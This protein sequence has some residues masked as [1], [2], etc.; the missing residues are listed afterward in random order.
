MGPGSRLPKARGKI[1]NM[2]GNRGKGAANAPLK[3]DSSTSSHTSSTCGFCHKAGHTTDSYRRRLA[4][5]N[6]TLYQQTR[7][8]FNP[9]QQLSWCLQSQCDGSSCSPPEEPLFFKQINN[10]ICDEI[11]P[12]LIKNAKLES[13]VGSSKPLSPQ[14]FNFQESYWG[15]QDCSYPYAHQYSNEHSTYIYDV[16]NDDRF[17]Q[18]YKQ[19]SMENLIPGTLPDHGLPEVV[20]KEKDIIKNTLQYH[21]IRTYS[22]ANR[23]STLL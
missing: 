18:Y 22:S 20:D 5:H 6:N 21:S 13:P 14:E 9:R 4:L 12:L 15:E 8:K 2:Y 17:N 7:S 19:P 16:D 1:L 23:G 3:S 10:A 11:L